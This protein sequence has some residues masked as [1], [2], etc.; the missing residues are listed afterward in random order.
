MD[1]KSALHLPASALTCLIL[2]VSALTP[3][4]SGADETG[5]WPEITPEQW[6]EKP[7]PD[8]GGAH[9]IVLEEIAEVR[10]SRNLDLRYSHFIRT[11]IFTSAGHEAA[12]FERSF[13]RDRY[14]I[15]AVRAR[16]V[17]QDGTVTELESDQI[18]ETT[19]IKVR[20]LERQE[21]SFLVPGVE[22][23]SIVDIAYELSGKSG[24]WTEYF[25]NPIYTLKR[26]LRWF[27]SKFVIK[28]GLRPTWFS[29]GPRVSRIQ[30]QCEP[31]CGEPEEVV[32]SGCCIP[33]FEEEE[34][35]PPW[36]MSHTRY[37]I[38]Y[39]Y[40]SETSRDHWTWVKKLVIE[41][42]EEYEKRKG[43]LD[44]LAMEIGKRYDDPNRALAAAYRWFQARIRCIDDLSW[45]QE[46]EFGPEL[47]ANTYGE[48]VSLGQ[49]M[50]W[51]K[52]LSVFFGGAK[53][54]RVRG[55]SPSV[56]GLFD[57]GWGTEFEINL[58]FALLARELGFE[59]Y[60]AFVQDRR[61]YSFEP[62]L[63][64]L[65]PSD[66]LTAIRRSG[67]TW[68]FYQPA[69]RFAPTGSVPWRYRGEMTFLV[70]TG[71]QLL[72]RIGPNQ[73]W[74]GVS[75]WSLQV[76]LDDVGS[77]TGE[78][79]GRLGGEIGREYKDWLWGKE[80]STWTDEL[81][82]R[83][84]QA[85]VPELK[86]EQP[87]IPKRADSLLVLS[88]QV[89]YPTTAVIAGKAM[90]VPMKDLIPWRYSIDFEPETRV[91]PVLL[92]Y[93]RD[94]TINVDLMLPENMV[95]PY[96]PPPKKFSNPLGSWS[97]TW[98]E[99]PGGVRYERVVQTDEAHIASRY[100]PL[101]RQFFHK[102]TA[103]DQQ[104]LSVELP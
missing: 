66:C 59:S 18:M 27:P 1:L 74:G 58:A 9:A 50:G 3:S 14:E 48:V 17:R 76:Q 24:G 28:D 29:Y 72:T 68:T 96:L 4:A 92:K 10:Q 101:V 49:L 85:D 52:F 62:Q 67:N 34:Y 93:P 39:R 35:A 63:M 53:I 80:P 70:G 86:L 87:E 11:K 69:S 46:Q 100:Y 57:R 82:D 32:F 23:G 30:V 94:E 31:S 89:T 37:L 83:I 13:Y 41:G 71:R 77:L 64:G 56:E 97:I 16:S 8:S 45:E 84:V 60:I 98:S 36:I 12:K 21:V 20:G 38:G 5:T 103:A 6:Q 19:I 7:R 95:V 65:P 78:V 25:E 51:K 44:D 33:A 26:T 88:G 91:Y 61:F 104:N 22:P 55:E 90:T 99:I 42:C 75:K 73:G 81:Q 2:C 54:F 79:T 43:P 40:Q 102:L 15:E 47:T